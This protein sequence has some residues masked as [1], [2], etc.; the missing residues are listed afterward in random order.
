MPAAS[1][2]NFVS[3]APWQFDAISHILTIGYAAHFAALA[4]FALTRSGLAPRFQPMTTMSVVVMVSAAL[5][6]LR[7]DMSFTDAFTYN[8]ESGLYEQSDMLFS[9]GYRYF[10]WL[11][12]VPLLLIQSMY[13]MRIANDKI[14][15]T[16]I[17]LATSGALMV[18]TGYIGQF[19][20]ATDTFQLLLWGTISTIFFAHF[21]L[22]FWKMTGDAISYLPK[23]AAITMRNIRYLFLFAWGLYP[24][25]YLLPLLGLTGEVAVGRTLLFT[26][27]DVVSKI[28]YGILLTKIARD[29]SD[30]GVEKVLGDEL[31]KVR[32]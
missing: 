32:A 24:I 4:Y 30:A 1:L 10:N 12:D 25:A 19:F 18:I 23:G 6:L 21:S 2:E 9:H 15:S 29:I 8:A 13:V 26:V 14:V 7:L 3:L 27:A 22:I 28:F 17:K 31:Q 20:E 11:I 16:R 5:L